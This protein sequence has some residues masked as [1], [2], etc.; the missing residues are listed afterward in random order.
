MFIHLILRATEG[1]D[2]VTIVASQ[3]IARGTSNVNSVTKLKLLANTAWSVYNGGFNVGVIPASTEIPASYSLSQNY[4][5]PFNPVTKI[6]YDLP[7]AGEVKL[8]IFDAL[9]R[10]I[11]T[12]V[13]E[14]QSAGTYEATFDGSLYPSGIYFYRLTADAFSGTR[15]MLMIK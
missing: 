2:T 1:N 9:G 4:P 13:N 15:K 11:E 7:S 5:N 8:V 14:N 3:L 10:E 12:L 6:K